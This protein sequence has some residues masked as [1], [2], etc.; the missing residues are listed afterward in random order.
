MKMPWIR[1]SGTAD[2]AGLKRKLEAFAAEKPVLALA[3]WPDR[4]EATVSLPDAS[5][6]L[7]TRV[8]CGD[9]ELWAHRSAIGQPF[10][11]RIADDS[12]LKAEVGETRLP[13]YRMEQLQKLDIDR[14]RP[15]AGGGLRTTGGR[16]YSLPITDEN[17]VRIAIYIDYDENGAAG[18]A[19]FRVVG[20]DREAKF[21]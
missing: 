4:Y 21:G 6:L 2:E 3:A 9:C 10:A 16:V 15:P 13:E 7:E 17:A 5:R 20:F 19:D 8:V 18:I 11:W 12:A 1:E 14:A